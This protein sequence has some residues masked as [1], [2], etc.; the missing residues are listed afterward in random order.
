MGNFQLMLKFFTSYGAA[1]NFVM[2][3]WGLPAGIF[4]VEVNK[5]AKC[6]AE[7]IRFTPGQATTH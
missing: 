3:K 4:F 2:K 1:V 6:R 7:K 5:G